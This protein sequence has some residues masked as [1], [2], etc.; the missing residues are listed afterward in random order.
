MGVRLAVR[1]LPARSRL[2]ESRLA[3]KEIMLLRNFARKVLLSVAL[4]GHS[5]FGTGMSQEKIEELLHAMHQTSVEAT[6][7]DDEAKRAAGKFIK[8][9]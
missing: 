3:L 1:V 7:E 6:I 9:E 2:P 4:G 8:S 5:L